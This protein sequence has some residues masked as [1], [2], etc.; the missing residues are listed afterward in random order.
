MEC[1]STAFFLNNKI[2]E[3][4]F[5]QT[6]PFVPITQHNVSSNASN[7]HPF[8]NRKIFY[9]S[10]QHSQRAGAAEYVTN[11]E[12]NPAY[13]KQKNFLFEL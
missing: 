2:F 7:F 6:A 12:R 13:P 10:L 8:P 9:L 1:K 5:L 4:V 11:Y 3:K